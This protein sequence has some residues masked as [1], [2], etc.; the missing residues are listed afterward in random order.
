MLIWYSYASSEGVKAMFM[1]WMCLKCG[2]MLETCWKHVGNTLDFHKV[3]N[4]FSDGLVLGSLGCIRHVFSNVVVK[5]S[6]RH[7]V[8]HWEWIKFVKIG[9]VSAPRTKRAPRP[10]RRL[11]KHIKW[12]IDIMKEKR[13]WIKWRNTLTCTHSMTFVHFMW[14]SSFLERH[15]TQ[16]TFGHFG[17]CPLQSWHSL[18]RLEALVGP[19][20]SI[21]LLVLPVLPAAVKFS[22][23]GSHSNLPKLWQCDE[24]WKKL[25][26][27]DI[28]YFSFRIYVNSS[29]MWEPAPSLCF[30]TF[31]V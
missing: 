5:T 18:D 26:A 6:K 10:H 27:D 13:K 20:T 24:N 25:K 22:P 28:W 30:V 19:T 8:L 9:K 4:G 1:F 12:R 3:W 15:I 14:S 11:K 23:P 2:N 31:R 21:L 16:Y 17:R 29:N 7:E